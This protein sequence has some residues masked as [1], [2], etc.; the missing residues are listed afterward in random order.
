MATS[1]LYNPGSTVPP[2]KLTQTIYSLVR[3]QR[4][5]EAVQ[6]L[7]QQLQ[8]G[9]F[10]STTAAMQRQS[11]NLSLPPLPGEYPCSLSQT[12]GQGSPC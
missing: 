4:F 11:H 1:F 7:E 10:L 2:G 12:A 6:L 5:A 8:V 9:R 3:G